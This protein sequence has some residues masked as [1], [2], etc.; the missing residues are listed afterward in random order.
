MCFLTHPKTPSKLK[1]IHLLNGIDHF[2][3]KRNEISGIILIFCFPNKITQGY[4][5]PSVPRAFQPVG[6]KMD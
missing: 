5:K 1:S 4:F 3:L 6:K 2:F